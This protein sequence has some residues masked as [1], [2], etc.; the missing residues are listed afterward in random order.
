MPS[1]KPPRS[2]GLLTLWL[3][4]LRLWWTRRSEQKKYDQNMRA[5]FRNMIGSDR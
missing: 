3:W 5:V 1:N 2:V 4:Q